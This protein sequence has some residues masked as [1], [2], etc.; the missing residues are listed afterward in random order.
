VL[1]RIAES[2]YWLGRY[3]ERAENTARVVDDHH[4]TLLDSPDTALNWDMLLE[5]AGERE[6]YAQKFDAITPQ[7]VETFLTFDRNNPSS[8]LSCWQQARENA[9]GIRDQI[10]S[11]LWIALNRTYLE[12]QRSEWRSPGDDETRTNTFYERVKESS[13]L[14]AGLIYSTILHELGWDF[15]Q[16]GRHLE[17]ALQTARI[18]QVHYA[19]LSSRDNGRG[20][21]GTHVNS[22]QWLPLLRSVS[23]SEAYNKVYQARIEPMNVVEM[24]VLHPTFPRSLRYTSAQIQGLLKNINRSRRD[25]YGNE[26]ERLAGRLYARLVYTRVSEIAERGVVISLDEL[27]SQL[28]EIG[29]EIHCHFFGYTPASQQQLML[30]NTP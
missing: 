25:D 22:S 10:S 2:H 27:E 24:L 20:T 12:L 18:L 5:I 14:I 26:P 9:R 11:E 3:V 19:H 6:E 4:Q 16:L 7:Q 17:R 21:N 8:I 15:L 29:L 28:T 23:A 1:S 13:Q 30:A